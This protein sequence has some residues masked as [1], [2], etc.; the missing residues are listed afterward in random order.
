MLG[1]LPTLPLFQLLPPLQI[2]SPDKPLHSCLCFAIEAAGPL[3]IGTTVNL[4]WASSAESPV[5]LRNFPDIFSCKGLLSETP[6]YFLHRLF[7]VTTQIPHIPH[8][9]PHSLTLRKK[10]KRTN[11]ILWDFQA[12][13]TPGHPYAQTWSHPPSADL[14]SSSVREHITSCPGFQLSPTSS[15]TQI[16]SLTLPV[17]APLF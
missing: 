14:F 3:Q 4:C 12:P 2:P 8:F 15:G 17:S 6:F 5:L 9:H 10:A 16:L 1:S 11:T 7:Q 13:P